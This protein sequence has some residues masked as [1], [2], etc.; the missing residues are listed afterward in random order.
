[1]LAISFGGQHP[2]FLGLRPSWYFEEGKHGGT[3]NDLAI[4]AIDMIPWATGLRF[5][6]IN[7]ARCWNSL[8]PQFPHFKEAGQ[9]MLTL[10]NGGGVLGDVSY[11]LPDSHGYGVPLY[12]RTTFF[13]REGILET[14]FTATDITVMKQGEKAVRHEPLP[15]DNPGGYL[16]SFLHEIAGTTKP[17]ELTMKEVLEASRVTLMTQ[18]C[19]DESLHDAA[20]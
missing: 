2:L 9:M 1:V 20:L 5:S 11:F 12:W 13:G 4:H 3:I 14:S 16:D 6:R 10:E 19:A 8:A 17:G 18:K 15:P 7:A